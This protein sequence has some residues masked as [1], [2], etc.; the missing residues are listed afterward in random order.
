MKHQ[1]DEAT[2]SHDSKADETA[3]GCNRKMIKLQVDEMS[4]K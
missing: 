4:I 1:I 3:C 2:I